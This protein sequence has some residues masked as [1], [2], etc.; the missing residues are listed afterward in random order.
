MVSGSVRPVVP[1]SDIDV[2]DPT[3]LNDDA[4][5]IIDG[6]VA[7]VDEFEVTEA[8]RETDKDLAIQLVVAFGIGIAT[9]YGA[10]PGAF[11]TMIG[12]AM[13]AILNSLTKVWR[14]RA[15]HAAETLMDAADEAEVPVDEFFSNAVADDRRQELF[16]RTMTIAQDTSLRE[17][18]RAL[19]RALAAGVMGDD[20]QINEELLFIRA[21]GDIDEVHIRLLNLMTGHVPGAPGWSPLK[22]ANTDP[23]FTNSVRAVLGTLELHGLIGQSILGTRI[24]GTTDLGPFYVLA[25]AGRRLLG[26]LAEETTEAPA[27]A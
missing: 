27:E 19:G 9:V 2:S 5:D 23:V 3:E 26:R 14:R 15:E 1:P 16:T 24:Q 22:I 7:R 10:I 25:D 6:Q 17:K 20:D 8:D 13:T 12:P 18:R 11:A 4:A 21:V